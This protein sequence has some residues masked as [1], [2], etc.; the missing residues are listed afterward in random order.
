[1]DIARGEHGV[2]GSR[3]TGGGFGG[4][5]VSIIERDAAGR[6][7]EAITRQ[8]KERT[9]HTCHTYVCEVADGAR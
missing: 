3:L 4:A 2:L 8:Y 7:S 9:G 5:T 1:V 6:V